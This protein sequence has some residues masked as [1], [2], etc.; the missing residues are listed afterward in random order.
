MEQAKR[1]WM[2]SDLTLHD[3]HE[4]LEVQIGCYRYP[5]R[6]TRHFIPGE[7]GQHLSQHRIT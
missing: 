7:S 2:Q 6:K 5:R 1:C 3:M 4:I